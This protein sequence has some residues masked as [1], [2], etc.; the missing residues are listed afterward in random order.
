MAWGR[1]EA[2]DIE[3]GASLG[4]QAGPVAP[5]TVRINVCLVHGWSPAASQGCSAETVG[6]SST[7]PVQALHLRTG[8]LAIKLHNSE[9]LGEMKRL[10]I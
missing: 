5:A 8:D 9:V 10:Y 7:F 6:K 2:A 3:M 1:G 4:R